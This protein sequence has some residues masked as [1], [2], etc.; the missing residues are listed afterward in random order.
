MLVVDLIK[1]ISTKYQVE[2]CVARFV[3][4]LSIYYSVCFMIN[5]FHA[6]L[7][8]YRHLMSKVKLNMSFELFHKLF[9]VIVKHVLVPVQLLLDLSVHC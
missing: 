8:D 3:T 9:A 2:L 6:Y 7:K 5:A 1:D 4:K